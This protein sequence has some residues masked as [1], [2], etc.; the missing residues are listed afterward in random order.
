MS[1][2]NLKGIDISSWQKGLSASSL[3]SMDFAILKIGEGTTWEDPE[4]NTFYNMATIPLG[5]YL[6][7]HA[8]T[9][10]EAIAEAKYALSLVA[11]RKLPLGIYMDIEE[12]KQIALRDSILTAVVK[13]FCDTIRAAG[14]IPGAYGSSGNL[15]AKVGP[16][17]VGDDVMVWVAQW[18]IAEPRLGDIWQYTD[19]ERLSGFNGNIDGNKVLTERFAKLIAEP[20]SE[21]AVTPDP[22]PIISNKYCCIMHSVMPVLR[23][24]PSKKD[25]YVEIA[26]RMLIAKNYACGPNAPDG[27]FGNATLQAVKNFEEENGL[28][29][30][31]IINSEFWS[32]LLGIPYTLFPRN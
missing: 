12:A 18:T 11:G 13:A 5:A 19:H 9:E 15:W 3:N 25:V 10:E 4:F 6:Y 22:E 16:S 8:T 1:V 7:S 23:Y 14:Y 24:N 27:Y 26:Q 30:L 21:P 17:Y 29:K 20:V 28:P 31:G 2:N 32:K